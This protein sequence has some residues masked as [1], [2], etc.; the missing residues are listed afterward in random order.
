MD[1]PGLKLTWNFSGINI[2]PREAPEAQEVKE[3]GN[4]GQPSIG[5]VG[6]RPGCATHVQMGLRCYPYS[7]LDA[8]FDL[9]MPI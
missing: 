4:E 8:Q 5:G 9:K 3:G 1:L 2:L 7:S 6:P